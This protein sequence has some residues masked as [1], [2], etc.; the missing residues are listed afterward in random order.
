MRRGPGVVGE[1]PV[2]APG[3]S[4]EY[5]SGC[6]LRTPVGS[7][8]GH[9]EMIVLDDGT[10]HQGQPFQAAIGKFGLNMNDKC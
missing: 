3:Q 2:L 8:E 1:Q 10:G 4:F 5:S 6:P 9:Y 7:M